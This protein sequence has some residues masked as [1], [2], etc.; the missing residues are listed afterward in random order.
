VQD[1]DQRKSRPHFSLPIDQSRY[2]KVGNDA[3]SWSRPVKRA[4]EYRHR[5]AEAEER[6]KLAR[7]VEAKRT[8]EEI[9]RHWRRM[10]EQAHGG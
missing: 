6:A 2:A 5:A 1:V 3:L 8:Y 7:N 10:A 9:A 4:E